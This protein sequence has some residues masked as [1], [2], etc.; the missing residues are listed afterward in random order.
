[1]L[2]Q[3]LKHT[4]QEQAQKHSGEGRAIDVKLGIALF[5]DKRVPLLKKLLALGLGVGVV[6][7]VDLLELPL[8]ALLAAIL[9]PLG[10]GINILGDGFEFVVGT[11]AFAA[12]LLPHLSPKDLVARVR[13]ERN[14]MI[15]VTPQ[16][17]TE[18][19][20]LP[21]IPASAAR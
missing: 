7:L 12:S 4:A 19:G 9:G 8:E 3:V 16:V 17:R 15:N 10:F 20:A 6:A 13:Q 2:K 5:K 21:E 18:R 14:G 1:M 11:M